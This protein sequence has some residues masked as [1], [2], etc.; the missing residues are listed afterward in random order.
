[1]PSRHIVNLFGKNTQAAVL[2]RS[3]KIALQPSSVND[4]P[5]VVIHTSQYLGEHNMATR[6]SLAMLKLAGR[7][8]ADDV[9]VLSV[10][11][12]HFRDT[13]MSM[14]FRNSDGLDDRH[15]KRRTHMPQSPHHDDR[16]RRVDATPQ[17]QK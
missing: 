9:T 15:P 11:T 5:L 4:L 2:G 8:N 17:P 13:Q 16:P 1:M 12:D 10:R 6:R 7:L 3:S 14:V